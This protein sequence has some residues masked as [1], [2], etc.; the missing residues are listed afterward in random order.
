MSYDYYND[1][2]NDP[3]FMMEDSR[4]IEDTQEDIRFLAEDAR[5]E[6]KTESFFQEM[7]DIL[8]DGIR[9]DE[10]LDRLD[11]SEERREEIKMIKI[12]K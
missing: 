1:P 11:L 7:A 3:V 4:F 9:A 2:M 5:E 12:K 10:A 6:I 8:G